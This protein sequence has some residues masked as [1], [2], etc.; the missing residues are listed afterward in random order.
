MPDRFSENSKLQEKLFLPPSDWP[1]RPR[2]TKLGINV[3]GTCL[4]QHHISGEKKWLVV[5]AMGNVCL[6]A[7][8]AAEPSGLQF[9]I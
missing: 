2:F 1:L 9:L 3:R 5:Q 8:S 6:T 7:N 4:K